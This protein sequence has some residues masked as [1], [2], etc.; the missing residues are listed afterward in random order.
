[1]AD[2][3]S[4]NPKPSPG[5]GRDASEGRADYMVD[6]QN[7]PI[8]EN[9][10][11]ADLST[12]QGRL[13]AAYALGQTGAGANMGLMQYIAQAD[14]NF[15][16]KPCWEIEKIKI[17]STVYDVTVAPSGACFLIELS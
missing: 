8:V 15:D 9:L 13:K 7:T 3:S 17:G 2:Y 14:L 4:V 6:G 16:G 11:S 1:M 12:E 10:E 5:T